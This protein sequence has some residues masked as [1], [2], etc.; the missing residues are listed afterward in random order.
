MTLTKYIAS[1]SAR[2]TADELSAA[3]DKASKLIAAAIVQNTDLEGSYEHNVSREA[4]S[5][6]DEITNLV[7][8]RIG[9][10]VSE[11]L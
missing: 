1:N 3:I 9:A 10:D 2:A 4:D 11:W 5:L 7:R 6:A 8:D